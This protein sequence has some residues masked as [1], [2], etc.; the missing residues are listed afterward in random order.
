MSAL[1]ATYAVSEV[2]Q[3][4]FY[5]IPGSIFLLYAAIFL[6][7]FQKLSIN[8]GVVAGAVAATVPVGF[9]IYQAYTANCLWIYEFANKRK[10]ETTIQHIKKMTEESGLK[11]KGDEE[12][13]R[14]SKRLLTHITVIS[15]E[16]EASYVWRLVNI[17]NA[18]GACLFSSILAGGVP[19]A[20]LLYC[21]ITGLCVNAL[22]TVAGI[23]NI[24]V[25]YGMLIACGYSSYY[26]IPKV[27][28]QL[29]V[30]NEIALSKN[31]DVVKDI[32]EKWKKI[33]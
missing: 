10:K 32:I 4:L 17:V 11:F 16:K 18:R 15:P 7:L 33:G 14:F 8:T 21:Q 28:R 30:Y 1:R 6:L 31:T 29:E 2:E 24:T 27:K 3:L 5:S 20:Y 13:Y 9:L 26:G 25:Y 19:I 23:L 12:L 22:S